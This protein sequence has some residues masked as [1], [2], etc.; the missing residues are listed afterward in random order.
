MLLSVGLRA[1]GPLAVFLCGLLC[2]LRGC[3]LVCCLGFLALSSAN[4]QAYRH[5]KPDR[6]FALPAAFFVFSPAGFF[7]IA[8]F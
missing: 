2:V 8:D 3:F 6:T 1:F 4:D 5:Q 7:P